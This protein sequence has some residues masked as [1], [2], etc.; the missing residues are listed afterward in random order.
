MDATFGPEVKFYAGPQ[1][2]QEQNQPPSA[3]LQFFGLAEID[4]KTEQFTV[5]LI[6]R[7]DKELFKVTLDPVRTG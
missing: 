3:G 6:D 4:G 7:Q 5:R 2:G 1:A